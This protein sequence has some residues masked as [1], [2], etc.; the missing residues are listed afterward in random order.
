MANYLESFNLLNLHVINSIGLPSRPRP[1]GKQ[2]RLAGPARTRGPVLALV[3]RGGPGTLIVRRPRSCAVPAKRSQ[4][5]LLE[6]EGGRPA[7]QDLLCGCLWG[8][9]SSRPPSLH[10][11]VLPGRRGGAG[12]A[13]LTAE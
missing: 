13:W 3:L 4:A 6:T 5:V 12:R 9:D 8:G 11:S 7:A 10:P 1:G 2:R